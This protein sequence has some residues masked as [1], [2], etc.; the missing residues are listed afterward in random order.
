MKKSRILYIL[1]SVVFALSACTL[2]PSS[3]SSGPASAKS[4]VISTSDNGVS[5]SSIA[6]PASWVKSDYDMRKLLDYS[7][8]VD[9]A[10][11]KG[12]LSSGVREIKTI[13]GKTV[14][15]I[16]P[17]SGTEPF[18]LSL[19]A[20]G[21]TAFDFDNM[22][23]YLTKVEGRELPVAKTI[24]TKKHIPL[25]EELLAFLQN[26]IVQWNNSALVRTPEEA[27][28]RLLA[29][30]G[31]TQAERVP[32]P[33]GNVYYK[34]LIDNEMIYFTV[35]PEFGVVYDAFLKKDIS[36]LTF[37]ITESVILSRVI[38]KE[39]SSKSLS[40]PP[41]TWWVYPSGVVK[42]FT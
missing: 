14:R 24:I 16:F 23:V 40:H 36:M 30:R 32:Y 21:V 41:K 25:T 33:E 9:G 4:S 42:F 31:I 1:L 12:D 8:Y 3:P 39:V 5:S 2:S 11:E 37:D 10:M 22:R 19:F 28:K 34:A 29:E 35:K 38:S 20:Q 7:W 26:A 13:D 27:I 18:G 15:F 17:E 6:A